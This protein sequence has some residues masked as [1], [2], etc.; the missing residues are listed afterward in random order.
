MGTADCVVFGLIAD[1]TALLLPVQ[2]PHLLKRQSCANWSILITGQQA[3][4]R[5]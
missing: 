4:E 2:I 3:M 5:R 1:S